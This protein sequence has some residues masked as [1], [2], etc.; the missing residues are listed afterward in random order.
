MDISEGVTVNQLRSAMQ[1]RIVI[2]DIPTDIA[3]EGETLRA[4]HGDVWADRWMRAQTLRRRHFAG[5]NL[6]TG[7]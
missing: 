5:Q 2:D 1:H 3:A 7:Q 6:R 4:Q